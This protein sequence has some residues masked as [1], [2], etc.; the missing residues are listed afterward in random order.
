MCQFLKPTRE[1]IVFFQLTKL[2]EKI[3]FTVNLVLLAL[4]SAGNLTK[5]ENYDMTG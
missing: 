5:L 4:V 1:K 3:F 2:R